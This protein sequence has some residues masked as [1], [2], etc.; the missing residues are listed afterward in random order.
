MTVHY[1][2]PEE[3]SGTVFDETSD[4]FGPIMGA[5]QGGDFEA[6]V[7]LLCDLP[8]VD[9]VAFPR[10]GGDAYRSRADHAFIVRRD[11]I[12]VL[13]TRTND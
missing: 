7:D 13:G 5:I 10:F 6:A 9:R 1:D 3:R 2:P 12:R 4:A 11:R 8:G